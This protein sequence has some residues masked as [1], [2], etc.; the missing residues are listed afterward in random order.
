MSNPFAPKE[1]EGEQVTL[2]VPVLLPVHLL[3]LVKLEA[4][5]RK[6]LNDYRIQGAPTLASLDLVSKRFRKEAAEII[7]RIDV[8]GGNNGKSPNA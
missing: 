2:E 1:G 3:G 6:Y 8:K 7:Q 4:S 5:V